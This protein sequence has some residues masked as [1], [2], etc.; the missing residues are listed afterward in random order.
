MAKRGRAGIFWFD[1]LLP[2]LLLLDDME[3]KALETFE[4]RQ[5][6]VLGYAQANAPWNDRTGA[7][8]DG[9]GTEVYEEDGEIYLELY[10]SVD[11]GQWLEVIQNGRFAIIMPTLEAFADEIFSDAGGKVTGTEGPG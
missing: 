4:E 5:W 6:D 9:L 2:V 10:H 3:D 8:R 11:Y 1:G 7:A